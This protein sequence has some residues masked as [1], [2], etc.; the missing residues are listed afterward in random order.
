[1]SGTLGRRAVNSERSSAGNSESSAERQPSRGAKVVGR[2]RQY[3]Y[4][5]ADS[6]NNFPDATPREPGT[7]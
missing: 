6:L 5:L 4:V 2:A 3:K 7:R 1:M